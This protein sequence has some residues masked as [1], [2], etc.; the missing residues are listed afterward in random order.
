MSYKQIAFIL[1][2]IILVVSTFVVG[3]YLDNREYVSY[4]IF[5]LLFSLSAFVV[6]DKCKKIYEAI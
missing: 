3:I 5:K 6:A 4:P 1:F 2:S